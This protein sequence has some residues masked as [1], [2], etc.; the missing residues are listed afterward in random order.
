MAIVEDKK[1]VGVDFTSE[2][3]VIRG[4]ISALPPEGELP[5]GYAGVHEKLRGLSGTFAPVLTL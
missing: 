5:P 3:Q 2:R 4:L 1:V